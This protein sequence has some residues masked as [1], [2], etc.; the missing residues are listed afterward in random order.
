MRNEDELMNV[1]RWVRVNLL[2]PTLGDMQ[3]KYRKLEKLIMATQ[4][5]LKQ[6]I[7][8]LTVQVVKIGTETDGL[9]QLVTDL[10]EALA[11][12]GTVAPEV[13]AAF[14]ALKASVQAVD[15]LV[16]DQ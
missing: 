2:P 3:R 13:Q 7:E 11:A 1:W 9:K 12:A 10:E 5:E 15:D 14:D 8:D 16:A 4:A 6:Q